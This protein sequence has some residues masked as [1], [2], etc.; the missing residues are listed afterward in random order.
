MSLLAILWNSALKWEY[1]SFSHLPF[2]SLLGP[3]VES[4]LVLLEEAVCYN[5]SILLEKLLAFGLLH[6]VPQSQSACFRYLLTPT[7][8][9]KSRK[10]DMNG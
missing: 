1:L 2:A 7:F 4:S 6:F 8:A 9:C 5:Q 10:S 3:C